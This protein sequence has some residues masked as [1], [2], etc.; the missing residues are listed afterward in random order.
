MVT[1]LWTCHCCSWYLIVAVLVSPMPVSIVCR[2]HPSI[3]LITVI[4]VNWRDLVGAPRAKSA[5]EGA[6]SE[7]WFGPPGL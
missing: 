2:V 4:A 5:V 3:L 7:W 6:R 1:P